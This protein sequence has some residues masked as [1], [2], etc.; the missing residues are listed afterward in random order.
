MTSSIQRPY[1]MGKRIFAGAHL[2]KEIRCCITILGN[3]S[4]LYLA[5]TGKTI[6]HPTFFWPFE[7]QTSSVFRSPLW[8]DFFHSHPFTLKYCQ[9]VLFWI[10]IHTVG[11]RNQTIWKPETF[12]SQRFS[13]SG[14]WRV[15]HSITKHISTIQKPD[16]SG[17]WIPTVFRNVE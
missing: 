14:F 9:N 4:P 17:F 6:W 1:I 3:F 13:P 5:F 7:Y 11:I 8:L 2:C 12:E 16:M 10:L 15:D